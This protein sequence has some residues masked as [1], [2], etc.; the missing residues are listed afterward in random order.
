MDQEGLED[1]GASVKERDIAQ[2]VARLASAD[3]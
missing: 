2:D 3:Y 1:L